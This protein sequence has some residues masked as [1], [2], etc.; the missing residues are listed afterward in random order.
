MPLRRERY[1]FPNRGFLVS[2]FRNCPV[3]FQIRQTN[4]W[5][6]WIFYQIGTASRYKIICCNG[7]KPISS[8]IS[9]VVQLHEPVNRHRGRAFG[10][11]KRGTGLPADGIPT[12]AIGGRSEKI[13]LSG[14]RP[15]EL[16]QRAGDGRRHFIT[17]SRKNLHGVSLLP[18]SLFCWRNIKRRWRR[19]GFNLHWAWATG[20][21]A[22]KAMA[23]K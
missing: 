21:L 20:I 17:G 9:A 12:E 16:E 15:A 6:R 1:N 8:S 7:P 5:L 4:I 2:V 14:Y 11:S 10:P 3:G 23:S 13:L 19:G 18:E 22:A